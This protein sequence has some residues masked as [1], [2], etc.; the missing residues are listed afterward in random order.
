MNVET[1]GLE[2]SRVGVAQSIPEFV[3]LALGKGMPLPDRWWVF[4][5]QQRASWVP[6]PRIDRRE[7]VDYRRNCGWTRKTHED[8]LLTDFMKS[9]RPHVAIHPANLWEWMALAQ[10]HGLATRL[11]D[12]TDNALAA[13][14]FAV[15]FGPFKENAA[16]WCYLHKGKSWISA[17]QNELEPLQTNETL[18]FRPPHMTPRI[19]VQS[20]SFTSHIDD[21]LNWDGELRRIEIAQISCDQIRKQ[22]RML[23][24]HRAALFPDLDGITRM[25]NEVRSDRSV[26]GTAA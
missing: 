6:R 18:E 21:Y 8:R 26:P 11:L 7:F 25:L 10:H 23:G 12:W 16:V 24:I 4:R 22:L 14:Y 2:F 15:E 3:E 5:G 20:G 19:T 17:L 13:L 1:C 9:A